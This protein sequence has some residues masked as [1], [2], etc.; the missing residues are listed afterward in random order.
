MQRITEG[1]GAVLLSTTT[2]GSLERHFFR[3]LEARQMR[4]DEPYECT[5]FDRTD[6]CPQKI[7][8]YA[9]AV[10]MDS[11]LFSFVFTSRWTKMG[12]TDTT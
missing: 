5:G 2:E 7:P 8:D 1:Q 9:R 11:Q 6:L 3:F 10:Q 12:V 4:S